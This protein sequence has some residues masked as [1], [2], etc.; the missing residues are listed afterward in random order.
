MK[1]RKRMTDKFLNEIKDELRKGVKKKGHPF[2]YFTLATIGVDK[3]ARLRT[4]VLRKVSED[5]MLTFFTDKRSKKIIHIKEN[6]RVSLLFYNSEELLQIRLQGI[7]T[8]QNNPDQL[9]RLWNELGP[10]SKKSYTTKKAPG[11]EIDK[12]N[13]L[14]YLKE[15]DYFT[16]VEIEPFKIEYLKL[17]SPEHL[18]I[19]FSKDD[20]SW[21]GEFLVP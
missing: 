16:A 5:L 2:R 11:S 20:H 21:K 7:A 9:K 4:L 3:Y 17:A 15:G 13:S 14:E 19:R 6:K 10:K 1:S 8:I 12:P 18:R